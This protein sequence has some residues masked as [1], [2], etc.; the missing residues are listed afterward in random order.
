MYLNIE[1]CTY[2]FFLVLYC[3]LD[4]VFDVH[5]GK[6]VCLVDEGKCVLYFAQLL[7]TGVT[8]NLVYCVK[9]FIE[10]FLF[11]EALSLQNLSFDIS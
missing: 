5:L 1:K 9:S 2:T 3:L 6:D 7:S 8:E 4:L 10:V 11:T